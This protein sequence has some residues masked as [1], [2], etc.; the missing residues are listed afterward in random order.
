MICKPQGSLF[1]PIEE[2]L[3]DIRMGRMVIVVD[4]EDRENEG[5]LVMAAELARPEDINFMI[6]YAR[7]LLCVPITLEQARRLKLDLMVR[8]SSDPHGTAFTVSVDAREGT[9]TGIS[10]AERAHTARVLASPDSRPEDLRR[11]GHVFPLAAKKGGV[12]KRAGHTEAAVDMARLAG[13]NP[14]GAICEIMNEDGSMARLPQLLEFADRHH[15]RIVSIEDLIRYRHMRDKLVERVASVRL[16]TPFGEFVAHAY[17]FVLDENQDLLHIA[18]VRGDVA[19]QENV[20]VRVHS[21]CFTGDVLGSLRCDCGPQLHKAM[22]IVQQEGRGVVLYMRQEGRGIGLFHKLKAYELQEKGLDTVEANV[23]LGYDPDLRDYGVGAQ[24]LADLGLK[25]IRILTNNPRKIV[26]LQGYG[27]KI[28][29]RVPLEVGANPFNAVYLQAKQEKMGHL[30]HLDEP[31]A[32]ET[33]G[34]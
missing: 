22:E 2:A 29:E 10:A 18:L 27:L 7:G 17:H 6:T 5:D 21:E 15:L 24:I 31:P 4:D 1:H 30:L 20:L 28:T 11:P 19:G 14:A 23:A 9:T 32:E 16:P 33:E 34:D 12:L 13:L 3:E 8:E 25:S 26:G